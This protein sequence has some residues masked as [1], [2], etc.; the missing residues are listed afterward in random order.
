M[1]ALDHKL[2][3]PSLET[4][5]VLRQ[6][7]DASE[8]IPYRFTFHAG[9]STL[10]ITK[11]LYHTL[12][13]P[14]FRTTEDSISLQYTP[15]A[16]FR[17]RAVSRCSSSIPGHGEAILCTAFSPASSSQLVT[18]SGDGTARLWDTDTGTPLHTLKGHTSWVLV[19]SWAP[20]G[21][22][23]ATGSMDNTVGL[24]TPTS[25]ETHGPALRGHTKWVT[26][27]AWEYVLF[28]EF[29]PYSRLVLTLAIG[30]NCSNDGNTPERM[31]LK[32][33]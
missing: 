29:V 20:D 14:G 6:Q 30:N 25:G 11:D 31:W 21:T 4:K 26:S 15:Q 22:I 18:G 16:I 19:A 13:K 1:W 5:P 9:D 23:I 27:L 3:S 7:Q 24:W 33:L 10:D 8:R 17:V 12:L 28:L 32:N 2:L